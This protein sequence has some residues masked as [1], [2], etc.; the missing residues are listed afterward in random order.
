MTE[1]TKKV[2]KG[3]KKDRGSILPPFT[4]STEELYSILE[5]WVKDGLV[6]LLECKHEPIE[7]EKQNSL[8]CR[9]HRKC[10]YH[11]M[12]CYVLGNIF[13]DRVA[14]GDLVIKVGKRANPRMC[15][16]LVAM[17]FFIGREDPMDKE[18]E[19]MASSSSAPLPL[20]DEEM[21]TR[22]Q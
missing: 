6:T 3:K 22:I 19:N 9:Y 13:Y 16:L 14:K 10:D 18:V 8:Y 20:V 15:R 2:A 4:V 12:D 7:E 11:T 17:T 21:V 1:E 5:A